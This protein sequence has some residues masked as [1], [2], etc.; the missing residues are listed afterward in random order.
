MGVD[1]PPLPVQGHLL[2]ELGYLEEPERDEDAQPLR[3]R[4]AVEVDELVRRDA[5]LAH[6]LVIRL[7]EIEGAAAIEMDPR[8]VLRPE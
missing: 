2:A 4:V 7:R 8:L 6:E 3:S 1:P 5:A